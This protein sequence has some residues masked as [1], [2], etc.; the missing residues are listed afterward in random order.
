MSDLS[1]DNTI[2]RATN[3]SRTAGRSDPDWS[4]ESGAHSRGGVPRCCFHLS[5][6]KK[7]KIL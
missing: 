2:S 6:S 5:R 4:L 3:C 7:K 1:A